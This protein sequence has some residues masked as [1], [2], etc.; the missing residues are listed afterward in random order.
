MLSHFDGVDYYTGDDLVPQDPGLTNYRRLSSATTLT[1]GTLISQW[2]AKGWFNLRDYL[3][4]GGKIVI[5]GR[6]AHQTFASTSTSAD[7]LLG[8]PV[9]PGP[10]LRVQLPGQQPR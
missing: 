4:E 3:N 9:Q 1:G 7:R 2:G 10:V 8:L 5:D 6:N